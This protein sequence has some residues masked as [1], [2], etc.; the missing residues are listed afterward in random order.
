MECSMTKQK[1][2]PREAYFFIT[3]R[4]LAAR[5]LRKQAFKRTLGVDIHR[6]FCQIEGRNLTVAMIT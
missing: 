3:A 6:R 1:Q 5:D 4:A 2:V